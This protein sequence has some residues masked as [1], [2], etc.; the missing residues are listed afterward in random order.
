[1]TRPAPTPVQGSVESG[2]PEPEVRRRRPWHLIVGLLAVL[3]V[4]GATTACTPEGV[5]KM[6]IATHW[7]TN[8]ACA[9]RVVDRESNFQF[10]AVNP[11]SGTTGLFQLHP[12]HAPWIKRTFGYEFSE[13]KDPFKNSEVAKALSAEAYRMYRDGWQ[14]WRLGGKRIPGGGCPA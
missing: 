12:V 7:G 11:S 4:A 2:N 8:A 13:M 6:A 9:E 1:M 3:T 14:P 5:A 10:E